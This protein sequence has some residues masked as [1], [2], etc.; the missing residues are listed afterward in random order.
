[1][2]SRQS[3][4]ALRPRARRW[5]A[6]LAATTASAVLMAGCGGSRV[7]SANVAQE[8]A[9]EAVDP[10]TSDAAA[11][12][13][14]AAPAGGAADEASSAPENSGEAAA[15]QPGA[16]EQS[17]VKAPV[18]AKGDGA[19]K[20][21]GSANTP[22]AK[23]SGASKPA[24]SAKVPASA[25]GGSLAA[26]VAK[27][28]ILGGSTAGCKPATGAPVT[29]GN[30]STLSGLLGFSSPRRFPRCG[31]SSNRRTSVVV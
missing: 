10:G 6:M 7:D 5:T 4:A 2:T 8:P 25:A 1:M 27:Q 29:I 11:P 30:V 9:A 15:P 22:A 31:F 24:S 12:D 26:A 23:G 21:A 13:T 17:G 14:G 16:A 28:A 19:K 18:A 3:A 20:A